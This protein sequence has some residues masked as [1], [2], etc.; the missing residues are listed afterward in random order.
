MSESFQYK[1][2]IDTSVKK[3]VKYW[4]KKWNVSPQ[5]LNGAIKATG[6]TNV[7]KV[8]EYIN[9]LKFRVRRPR[10]IKNL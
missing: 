2:Q 8:E 5:Q 7:T 3:E 6:S 4:T 1:S 10:F 9:Q